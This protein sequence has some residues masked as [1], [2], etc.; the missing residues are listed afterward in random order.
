MR[1]DVF[2]S[3]FTPGGTPFAWIILGIFVL[4]LS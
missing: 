3:L 1:L 4:S 2:A